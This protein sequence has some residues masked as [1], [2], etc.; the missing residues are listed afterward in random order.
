MIVNENLQLVIIHYRRS[1]FTIIE[2]FRS[3]SITRTSFPRLSIK[4]VWSFPL[5]MIPKY[6]IIYLQQ[7]NSICFILIFFPAHKAL[8]WDFKLIKGASVGV[9]ERK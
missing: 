1:H 4:T 3:Q 2:L 8:E 7:L 9:G 5:P 6:T